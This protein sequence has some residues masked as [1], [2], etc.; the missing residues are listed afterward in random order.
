MEQVQFQQVDSDI[1]ANQISSG[2]NNDKV[3]NKE[4]LG[5]GSNDSDD[6]IQH[7]YIAFENGVPIDQGVKAI[8]ESVCKGQSLQITRRDETG[9]GVVA[10]VSGEDAKSIEKLNEVSFVKIDRGA[11]TTK[12]DAHPQSQT[13]ITDDVQVQEKAGEETIEE[14]QEATIDETIDETV[15]ETAEAETI[16]E[17]SDTNTETAAEVQDKN[18]DSGNSSIETPFLLGL[19]L[20]VFILIGIIFNKLRR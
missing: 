9:N 2:T 13:K 20:G 5:I 19:F 17:T 6:V 3:I 12:T 14:N 15:Q 8:E 10:L 16:E 18:I 1:L 11:E 7:V 4:E